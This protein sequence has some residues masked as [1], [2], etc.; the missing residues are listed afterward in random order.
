MIADE[1]QIS[2][3]AGGFSIPSTLPNLR[4]HSMNSFDV[5]RTNGELLCRLESSDARSVFGRYSLTSK[6]AE[7]LFAEM[8]LRL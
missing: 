5:Q 1:L 2:L 7:T 3:D 4:L 8:S 6:L